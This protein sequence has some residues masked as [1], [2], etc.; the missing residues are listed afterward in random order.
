MFFVLGEDALWFRFIKIANNLV[1][2][3]WSAFQVCW[4]GT[5]YDMQNIC[6]MCIEKV[7]MTI[8]GHKNKWNK[9]T[10]DLQNRRQ[11][12]YA[13]HVAYWKQLWKQSQTEC[14]CHMYTPITKHTLSYSLLVCVCVSLSLFPHV[15]WSTQCWGATFSERDCTDVNDILLVLSATSYTSP[16]EGTGSID[17][18]AVAKSWTGFLQSGSQAL[19]TMLARKYSSKHLRVCSDTLEIKKKKTCRESLFDHIFILQLWA[20]FV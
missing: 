4:D 5:I 13:R 20:E 12:S 7:I 10:K 15:W 2:K 3:L 9:I 1:L 11:C 6:C 18:R 19:A 17:R 16:W 14:M 8:W